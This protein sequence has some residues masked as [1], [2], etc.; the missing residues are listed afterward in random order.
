VSDRL[1]TAGEV[2]KLLSVPERW[3]K[4]AACDGRIPC[5]RLGRYVRF[6]REDVLSWVAE[7][8]TAGRP[9]AFRA[10]VPVPRAGTK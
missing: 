7:Q 1:L 3:V 4:D 8:K 5:V 6:D 2:A 10:H 9:T